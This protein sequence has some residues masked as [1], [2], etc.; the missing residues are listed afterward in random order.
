MNNIVIFDTETTST[1]KPFCYNIGYVILDSETGTVLVEKD[2]VIEQVWHNP[3]LFTTAYYSDKRPIYVKRMRQRKTVMDKFGYICQEM[4][5]DFNKYNVIGA[6]AYNSDFDERVF[7]FNCE[8]FR[9]INPFDEI[10]VFDIR[11]YAQQFLVDDEYKAF[12]E[13][14]ELFT[15][16]GNY[17]TTAETVYKFLTDDTEFVEEHTALADSKIEAD[18]L[19]AC[20]E[21]GARVNTPY[22]VYISIPRPVDKTLT[23]RTA[24]AETTY[25]YQKMT[26]YKSKDLIV[27]K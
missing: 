27:L 19:F 13:E 25:S 11:G 14:Y 10:P 7:N 26:F 16:S 3:M 1:N 4:I 18:I 20:I 21:S 23:I 9:C 12:C 5:R 15:D 6:Y 2:F 22:H 24:D 8:W 17:S